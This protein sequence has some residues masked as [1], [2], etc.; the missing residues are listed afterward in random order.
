MEGA[1]ADR[2]VLK[3]K[4]KTLK[5]LKKEVIAMKKKTVGGLQA[6]VAGLQEE[7][8]SKFGKE[9]SNNAGEGK[10]DPHAGEFLTLVRRLLST[11]ISAEQ[12][13]QQLEMASSY[14]LPEGATKKFKTPCKD[15][16]VKQREA[17]GHIS[18]IHAMTKIAAAKE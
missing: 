4:V 2:T 13:K 17:V 10:D 14:F 18:W 15:W 3:K 8:S 16:S 5:T 7:A 12:H 9:H 1:L 11:M 6:K